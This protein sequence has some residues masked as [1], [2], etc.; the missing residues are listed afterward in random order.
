[1]LAMIKYPQSY[2]FPLS[3]GRLGWGLD[4]V[5]TQL[6]NF[7]ALLQT[8]NPHPSPPPALGRELN[9]GISQK[10]GCVQPC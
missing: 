7:Y 8:F 4:G 10:F 9:R 5:I 1:M 3:G 2:S 6:F